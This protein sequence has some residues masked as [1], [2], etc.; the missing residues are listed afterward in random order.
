MIRT[1]L[2]AVALLGGVTGCAVMRDQSTAGEYVDD[3]TITTQIKARFAKDPEV[4]AL[5]IEVHTLRGEVQLSG[6]AKNDD[7][8]ARAGQIAREVRGVQDVDN[9][10]IVRS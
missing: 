9:D 7:E 5:S 3:S 6:F 1:L 4:S 10:I 8:K 2:L